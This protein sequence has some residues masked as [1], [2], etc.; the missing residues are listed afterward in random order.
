M[1]YDLPRACEKRNADAIRGQK[2]G[3]LRQRE[4]AV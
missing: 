1:S 3:D 2:Q 4:Q